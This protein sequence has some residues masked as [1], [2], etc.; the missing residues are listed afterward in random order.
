MKRI[1]THVLAVLILAAI[2][3]FPGCTVTSPSRFYILESMAAN[4]V[5][6]SMNGLRVGIGPLS[7]PYYLDRPQIVSRSA[8]NEIHFAEFDRWAEPLDKNLYMVLTDNLSTL[9]KTNHVYAFPWKR[10]D[11]IMYHVGIQ[12]LKFELNNKGDVTIS[13]RWTLYGEK[14]KVLVK[15]KS[16]YKEQAKTSD[17]KA[18]VAAFNRALDRFSRDLSK[19]I[20]RLP[21]VKSPE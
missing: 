6:K 5:S 9:L 14:D 15:R 10:S 12:V 16:S 3:I 2:T 11:K 13:M 19:E 18:S 17:F 4:G 21:I 7:L 8:G 1:Q 20:K